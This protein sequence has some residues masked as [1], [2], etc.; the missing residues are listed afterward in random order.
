MTTQTTFSIQIRTANDAFQYDGHKRELDRILGILSE[1]IKYG[2]EGEFTLYDS[3][4]NR[5]GTAF[6][7]VWEL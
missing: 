5:I 1:E 6:L 4:G 2:Q 7:E 3:N